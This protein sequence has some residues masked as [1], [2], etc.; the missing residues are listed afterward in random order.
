MTCTLADERAA[1]GLPSVDALSTTMISCLTRGGAACSDSRQRARSSR[2]LNDTTI[3]ESSVDN[4][5]LSNRQLTSFFEHPQRL[6]RGAR[7]AVV[8]QHRR[9]SAEEA[10]PCRLVEEHLLERGGHVLPCRGPDIQRRV[11]AALP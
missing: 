8:G 7:P 5:Q 11:R 4:R 2:A 3:I 1:S 6:L 9:G 10:A